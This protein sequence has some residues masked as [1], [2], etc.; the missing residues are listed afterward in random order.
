VLRL[1]DLLAGLS[2]VADLGFGLTPESAMRSCIVGTALA[3]KVGLSE[4]EVAETFYA[5]LLLHVG[6]G[7]FAHETSNR[8]GDERALLGKVATTNVADPRDMARKVLPV[9]VRGKRPLAA[10]KT[11]GYL[12]VRGAAF[13][14]QFDTASCEAAS[15]VARRIGLG[16]GVQRA[17]YEI[18]EWW[19]GGNAPQN[20]KGDEIVLPARI[21]CVATDAVAYDDLHG[22]DAAVEGMRRKAGGILDPSLVE[23]FAASA[24]ELLAA[25]RVGDPR[26]LMLEVEPEP[27]LACTEAD[28]PDVAAAF[29][30]LVDVRTPYT[31]GHSAEVARL[32][33]GAGERLR[34]DASTLRRLELAARLHDLGRSA[35]SNSIWEKPGRLTGAEWEQVR[36]HPY[37]SERILATSRALEPVAAIAGMHHERLDGSGYHRAARARDMT[38]AARILAAA[39][40]FQ[41]MTQER[42]HRPALSPEQAADELTADARAG[43]LDPDAAS[44]VLDV[45]GLRRGRRSDLRPGGLS[46]REIEVV[47]LVAE[48]WSNPEIAKRLVISRRT[49]EHHVQ[50]VYAKLGVASRP[51]V[52]MFALEHDLLA[53]KDG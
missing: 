9:A 23:T 2:I 50:N 4:E 52:A 7:T 8:F 38:P 24:D 29:G 25:A 37:H 35:V 48:G 20:L 53:A 14:R 36:M 12:L 6:C 32:A 15:T 13:G 44:A 21:A 40:A 34:L 1:A 31:H 18:P 11:A 45:A 5:S 17:L 26:E 39:D 16:E 47:R 41:A 30:D 42:P 19:R 22:G 43:R 51:A 27:V 46:E 3:R 49:A 10:A 28:L 33:T